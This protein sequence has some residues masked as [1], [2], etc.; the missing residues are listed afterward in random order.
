MAW[1][2]HGP[3]ASLPQF[4][5]NLGPSSRMSPGNAME[6]VEVAEY[7]GRERAC[8]CCIWGRGNVS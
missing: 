6:E 4:P 2:V 3:M 8:A 1:S 5:M 7:R